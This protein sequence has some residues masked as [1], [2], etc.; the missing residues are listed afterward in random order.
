MAD[1]KGPVTVQDLLD[2]TLSRTVKSLGASAGA[3]VLLEPDGEVLT[4]E[5]IAG[6]PP[7]FLR[8]L[9]HVRLTTATP[10]PIIEAVRERHLVWVSSGEDLA[11]RYPKVALLLPYSRASA[12]APIASGRVVWGAL[13]LMMSSKRSSELTAG[14]RRAITSAGD[15]IATLLQHAADTGQ[16]LQ[17]GSDS[18]HRPRFVPLTSPARGDAATQFAT[19]LPEGGC[20]LDPRGRITFVEPTAA[21]LLGGSV[22]HLLGARLWDAVPWL[23]DPIYQHHHRDA[24]ISQLPTSFTALRPPDTHLHFELYPDRTG[25]SVRISPTCGRHSPKVPHAGG[26]EPMTGS[27]RL[28]ATHHLVHLAGALTEAATVRDVVDLVADHLLLSFRAQA[29]LLLVP[30]AGR[31]QVIGHRG[32][33]PEFVDHLDHQPLP[34]YIP[35]V[36]G[37]A[38]GVPSFFASREERRTACPADADIDDGMAAWA[39]LPLIASGHPIGICVLGYERPHSFTPDERTILI[40]LAALITQALDRA[41][42]YDAEHQLAHG[43]QDRLLPQTLPAIPGLDVAAR[44]LPASH[45]MDIGGDFYDLIRLTTTEAAAVIG[46]VQGHN[47]SAAGLMGQVR[48][49][50]HAYA[51]AGATPG[52]VLARTNRL[53]TDL[54]PDL[55]TSCLYAHLDLSHHS[56][57][58]ATAGHHPP[59]LRHPDTRTHIVPLLPGPLLGVDPAAAYPT[60]EVALPPGTVLALYTDGLIEAPGTDLDTNIAKL[61]ATLSQAGDLLDG[62]AVALLDQAT[63]SGSHADDTAL[64]LLRINYTLQDTDLIAS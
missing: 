30:E 35:S 13:A 17:P 18:G 21:E 47:V 53:L 15:R 42:Q 7:E 45:G 29:F 22:P 36:P 48:T 37:L 56:A 11:R 8:P 32:F 49:A 9:R 25:L 31:I 3:I 14:E 50:V 33:H 24:V 57:H 4:L 5:A 63:P 26:T 43:L 39:L 41:R 55:L 12:V 19:R 38:T 40:T 61:T 6:V 54:D 59:F 16:R 28:E 27:A 60:T 52:E 2:R 20:S 10:D 44:Y 58:L 64:L 51:I 23:N 62:I 34:S 1:G 46:D